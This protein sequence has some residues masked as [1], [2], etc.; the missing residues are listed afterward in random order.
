VNFDLTAKSKLI[1]GAKILQVKG[2]EKLFRS[3]FIVKEGELL[4]KASKC[5]LSTTSGAV[6]GRLFIS[7]DKMAFVQQQGHCKVYFP[8]WTIS[9]FPLQGGDPINGDQEN[10]PK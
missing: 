2:A 10:K 7:T 3:M 9:C 4:L 6:A 1:L 5:S 8:F